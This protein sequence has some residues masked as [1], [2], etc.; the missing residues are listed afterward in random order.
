MCQSVCAFK[1]RLAFSFVW[2]EVADQVRTLMQGIQMLLLFSSNFIK[3]DYQ[4]V[5]R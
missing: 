4:K 5:S 3:L 2:G 1:G